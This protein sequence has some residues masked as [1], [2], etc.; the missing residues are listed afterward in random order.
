MFCKNRRKEI[1]NNTNFCNH[2]NAAQ[3][4]STQNTQSYGERQSAVHSQ[5]VNTASPS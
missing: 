1:P 2:C 3:N 5:P 4:S